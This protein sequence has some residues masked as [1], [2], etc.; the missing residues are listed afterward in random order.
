MEENKITDE[1]YQSFINSLKTNVPADNNNAG[2]TYKVPVAEIQFDNYIPVK[3]GVDYIQIADEADELEMY[4]LAGKNYIIEGDKGLG[5]TQL[6]HNICVKHNLALVTLTC[7]EGTK[8]GEL[9]GRPQI[10]EFGSYYQLGILPT[11]IEV[12]NHFGKGVL[13]IDELNALTHE[14]QKT[15]N[16]ITDGRMS[17]NA[18]GK[19]YRV[20][21][22]VTLSVV[23]TMNPVTYSGV[24]SLTEDVRSRFIGSVWS[25]PDSDTLKQIIDWTNID[26]LT[27]MNPM[28]TLVQNIHNLRLNS[29]V[30]YSLSPRDIAQFTEC[31]KLLKDSTLKKPLERSLKN[32]V[33]CKFSDIGQRELIKKQ[34]NDIFGVSV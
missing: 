7:S 6:V 31:Y 8:I 14:I 9:I 10:N 22:G 21:S 27:V 11:A 13:Y 1:A 17:I 5:K 25:Y 3:W 34:I 20:N 16:S 32:T 4:M 24:N 28:L 15:L 30:D 26:E 2:H 19:V 23:G 33:M 29:D 12:A 18:N